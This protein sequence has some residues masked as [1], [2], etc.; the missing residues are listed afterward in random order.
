MEG[1]AVYMDNMIVYGKDME[2]H[3]SNLRGV[4]KRMENVGLKL[5]ME[6]CV[7]RKAEV[8]FLRHVVDAQG[9][10]ADPEKVC[11]I[12]D[13]QEPNNVTELRRAL[14]LINYMSKYIPDLATTGGPLYELLKKERVWTWGEPQK[15]AFSDLKSLFT[16]APVLAHYDLLKDTVVS[17][18]ASSYGI[19]GVLLQKHDNSWK[20]V[21]EEICPDRKGMPRRCMGM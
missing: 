5:N 11:A 1:V 7:F 16:K 2:E 8:N 12:S 3:D 15:S 21:E 13:L 14:G 4:L 10:R 18:D 6:K 17:A 9:V 19:G 20:P